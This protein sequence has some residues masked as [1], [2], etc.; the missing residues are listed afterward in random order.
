LTSSSVEGSDLSRNTAVMAAGTTLSRITGFARVFALAYALG[1][2]RLTDS[3]NLANTTPNIV[4]ELVVGGVLSAT[5]LPVFVRLFATRDEEDAW[6]GV[7]A[8]ATVVTV[9]TI[10]LSV[11][12]LAAAPV[13]IRLYTF[14]TSGDA[15]AIADQ[16]AVATFLLR[17]FAPQVAFYG[18]VTVMTALLH[19]RRRFGLPMFAPVLNN[20]VVIGVLLAFPHIAPSLSLHRLR[21]EHGALLWL[22]LGT[23]LGVIAMAIPQIAAAFRLAGRRLRPRW[24]PGHEAV[25]TVVRLSL[26]T[27]GFTAANQIA[28]WVVLLLANRK[29]GDLSAYQAS[30][31]YF[32]LLP[33]GVI[34]VS[35]MSALQPELAER[36]SLGQVDAFRAR[37][38][39][40][41]R[42][43]LTA[44]VPA[45]IGYVTLAR[46]IVALLIGHGAMSAS[47]ARTVANVLMTMAVG[48]PAFSAFLLL[49]RAFQ[50]I[51]DAREVFVLYL[52]ENGINIV[53]ALALYPSLG[54]EGLALAFALAYTG[55][56]VAALLAMRRRAGGIE[57]PA[58]VRTSL[59]VA[60]ASAAMA[61]IVLAVSAAVGSGGDARLAARVLAGVMAGVT[62]Y[63]AVARALG[64]D[65]LTALLRIGR[66]KREPG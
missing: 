60:V 53:L 39:S 20:L 19:A 36:W 22:G 29:A 4:Y 38:A 15:A 1:L 17:L 33:H 26:W 51:Q 31:Q 6:R 28:Y 48:L 8:I 64:V 7:S 23:T 30:Y 27:V 58:L 62:V 5:L 3:Y 45:A 66:G 10:G 25:R 32:F 21:H 37:M 44:L 43:V 65:E 12:L 61:A 63:V 2:T 57:G 9:V 34:A 47:D 40:G 59:R 18:L 50:A 42:M 35:L 13:F 56:T 52:I 46:P 54:V 41:L 49:V 55:G 16:R 14:A 11:L 24:E